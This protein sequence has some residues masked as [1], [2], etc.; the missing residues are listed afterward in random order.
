MLGI[1]DALNVDVEDLVHVNKFSSMNVGLQIGQV[2]KVPS[3]APCCATNICDTMSAGPVAENNQEQQKQKQE[4]GS[5][6]VI[7]SVKTD[8]TS[9][10]VEKLTA[11]LASLYEVQEDK[12]V[13]QVEAAYRRMARRSLLQME[14]PGTD[15]QNGL[16]SSNSF[17]V[18]CLIK[19]D[20]PES[21]LTH[22][23]S[24]G[25]GLQ[26]ALSSAGMQLQT[27]PAYSISSMSMPSQDA[28]SGLSVGVIVGIAVGGAVAL[29]IMV[30]CIGYFLRRA[31]RK[32]C[33]DK[34]ADNNMSIVGGSAD[35]KITGDSKSKDIITISHNQL[36]TTD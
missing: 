1:A 10:D 19:T 2:L 24:R 36:Y 33:S 18:V 31:K 25:S 27:S 12:V 15:A 11:A 22:L 26:S 34:A 20:D 32:Q 14:V 4:N 13:I 8:K 28:S 29:S 5:V 9:L 17:F 6:Q 23:E 30:L 7:F 35:I 3:Q 16:T 21:L